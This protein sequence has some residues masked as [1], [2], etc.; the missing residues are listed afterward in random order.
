MPLQRGSRGTLIFSH[1]NG[2]AAGTYAQ[3]FDHWRNAGWQ[4][5]AVERFGHDARYPV[6]SNW[7]GL[8]Q[9]LLDFIA[10]HAEQGR[11]HLVGHS[12]GGYLSVLA[13]CKRPDWVAGLVLMDSPLL[14]GWRAHSLQVMKMGGL[15]KRF[16]PGRVSARR[17]WQWPSREAA[18][19]HFQA[20][21]SFALW[22]A[23]V[24]R[25]YIAAGTEPDTEAGSES[26]SAE[27]VRLAFARE[28]ETR[29]YNTLPHHLGRLLK[30]RPPGCPAAFIGGTRSVELHQAGLASTRALVGPRLSWIEGSHLYPMEKPQESAAAVLD[31]LGQMPA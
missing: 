23:Q 24:L 25:D 21:P 26:G 22:Q 10:P 5:R 15:I 8:R 19:A 4:V 16:S 1:A 27:A 20:K 6:S 29:I 31:W 28:V 11:V 3:L 12:L 2:F 18:L 7:P 17:R 13:A 14:T 30:L 9:Q